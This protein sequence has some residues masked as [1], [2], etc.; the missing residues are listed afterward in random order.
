MYFSYKNPD[1]FTSKFAKDRVEPIL[2]NFTD[3]IER[4][5]K[6]SFEDIYG[7]NEPLYS[8]SNKR[9]DFMR[10]IY[11]EIIKWAKEKLDEIERE[12]RRRN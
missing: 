2:R 11:M 12:V 5:C 8:K 10:H 1:F 4:V 7:N 9:L 6:G 3:T